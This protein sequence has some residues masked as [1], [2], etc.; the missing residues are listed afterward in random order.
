MAHV[1]LICLQACC[2]LVTVIEPNLQHPSHRHVG[3]VRGCAPIH[4]ARGAGRYTEAMTKQDAMRFPF[5]GSC[6]FFGFFVLF[7]YLPKDLVNKLLTAYF[8]V[9]GIFA[10]VGC[11]S[12]VLARR[13]QILRGKYEIRHST[14]R[15][16]SSPTDRSAWN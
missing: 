11:L 10:L 7:K 9:L 1:L 8:V 15:F 14:R 2:A 16:R 4:Q 12:P 13:P 3:G 5:I 6:V